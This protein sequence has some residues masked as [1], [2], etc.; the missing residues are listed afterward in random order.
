MS[1][2]IHSTL[3]PEP[4]HP[5]EIDDVMIIQISWTLQEVQHVLYW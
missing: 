2:N 5:Y 1:R 4:V 3:A